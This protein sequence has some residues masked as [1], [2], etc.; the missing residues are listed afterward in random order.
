MEARHR[1]RIKQ[2]TQKGC[3]SQRKANRKRT[4]IVIVSD[5]E[6]INKTCRK[7]IAS[8]RGRLKTGPIVSGVARHR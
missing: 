7:V 8:H 1:I 6:G 3:K 4:E 5:R 2:C